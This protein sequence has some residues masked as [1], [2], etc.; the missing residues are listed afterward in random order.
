MNITIDAV[1]ENGALRL[2][3]PLSALKDRAKVRLTI[4][5]LEQVPALPSNQLS[6][7]LERIDRRRSAIYQRCGQLSD[8]AELI[9]EGRE[10]ELE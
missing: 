5:S 9:R 6:A 2:A 8:S 4:E 3:Q 10:E 1:Y 7:V